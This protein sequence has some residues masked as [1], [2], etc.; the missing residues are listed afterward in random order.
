MAEPKLCKKA[1]IGLPG[2]AIYRARSGSGQ[3]LPPV[4][5]SAATSQNVDA[6]G[7][8]PRAFRM[9][10]GC[11]TTTPCALR[12]SNVTLTFYTLN[13]LKTLAQHVEFD[14]RNPACLQ[15]RAKDSTVL[16]QYASKGHKPSRRPVRKKVALLSSETPAAS[17]ASEGR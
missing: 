1:K 16:D 13:T 17:E 2:W 15:C 8:N 9:R 7:I 5:R 3:K 4:N 12:I 6:L 10:S 14:V 11:D